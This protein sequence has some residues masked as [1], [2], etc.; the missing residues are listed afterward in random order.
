MSIR[1]S[2]KDKVYVMDTDKNKLGYFKGKLIKIGNTFRLYTM[3]DEALLIVNE[4]LISM[5]SPKKMMIN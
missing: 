4:K 5:K 2:L 1:G 3:N